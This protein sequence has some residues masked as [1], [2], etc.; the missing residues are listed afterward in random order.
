MPQQK[1][2]FLLVYLRTYPLQVIMAELFG[3][4]QAAVNPGCTGCCPSY[5]LPL[6]ICVSCR[7]GIPRASLKRPAVGPEADHRWNGATA[8]AA[9]K[10]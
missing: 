7:S 2:L 3:L 10:P 9:E 8:A 1:L 6:M 5:E 4:S